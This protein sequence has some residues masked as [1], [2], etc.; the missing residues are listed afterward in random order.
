MTTRA[1]G[2]RF[3]HC[4]LENEIY[5]VRWLVCRRCGMR[6]ADVKATADVAECA[7]ASRCTRAT[8][9]QPLSDN[10]WKGKGPNDD[11]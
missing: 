8:L 6:S 4:T 1:K 11:A 7:D 2:D 3:G 5:G 9:G 10:Q